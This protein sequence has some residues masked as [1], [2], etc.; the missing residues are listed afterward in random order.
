MTNKHI[1]ALL[2]LLKT[3]I[4]FEKLSRWVYKYIF[5]TTNANS[6]FL[7]QR[8]AL[9]Y[10]LYECIKQKVFYL[11]RSTIL[12]KR[13][14]PRK[15]FL[16]EQFHRRFR[17]WCWHSEIAKLAPLTRAAKTPGFSRTNRRCFL[18][19]VECMAGSIYIMPDVNGDIL[20]GS[21]TLAIPLQTEE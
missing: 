12:P 10:I 14:F 4:W 18:R 20:F 11:P 15:K 1:W 13:F 16:V 5:R 8:Y 3:K 6:F 21:P 2:P 9:M 19:N 17:N 7:G